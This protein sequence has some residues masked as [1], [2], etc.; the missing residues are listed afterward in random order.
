MD[1]LT[2]FKF[3][4]SDWIMGKIMK[5]SET[6]QARFIRLMC[7]YWNKKCTLTI[8]DAEI[9][10]DEEHLE[11]LLKKKIIKADDKFIFID[12]LDEQ[13][14]EIEIMREKRKKAAEARWKKKKSDS[15]AMQDDAS[16]SKNDASAM[17]SDAEKKR[18]EKRRKEKKRE[19]YIDILFFFNDQDFQ[20][21]WL[22]WLKVRKSKK[23]SASHAAM[24]RALNKLKKLSSDN[25]Q[26]AI[27]IVTRSTDSGWSDLYELQNNN[28]SIYESRTQ[29]VKRESSERTSRLVDKLQQDINSNQKK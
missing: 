7:L 22:E 12:F 3:T 18:E 28:Q 17:Q 14:D 15:N 4:P 11:V 13:I 1:K 27:Q 2:W 23:A 20:E 19:E 10:I 24:K 5:C 29:K 21:I 25:K 8:E 9:E 26:Q 16:A 6:T